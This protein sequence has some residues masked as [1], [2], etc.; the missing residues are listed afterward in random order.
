MFGTTAVKTY[1]A[2]YF[3]FT[4]SGNWGTV[5]EESETC[6]RVT[7]RSSKYV[8]SVLR[9]KKEWGRRIPEG[10]NLS[11]KCHVQSTSDNGHKNSVSTGL[12]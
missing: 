8:A 7:E 4:F 12:P 2:K 1:L 6:F 11:R 9:Y 10:R 3:R 5:C